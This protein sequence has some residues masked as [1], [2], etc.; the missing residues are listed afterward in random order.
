MKAQETEKRIGVEARVGRVP[1]R[2]KFS[3]QLT[4]S[5]PK[6]AKFKG[7]SLLIAFLYLCALVLAKF[8]PY[9]IILVSLQ[10]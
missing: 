2:F 5:R 7:A 10:W 4:L 3:A 1:L 6:T 9:G 8:I